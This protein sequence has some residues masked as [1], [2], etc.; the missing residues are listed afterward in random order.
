MV[1][2]IRCIHGDERRWTEP[3]ERTD[4]HECWTKADGSLTK[5]RQMLDETTIDVGQN[6]DG[7]WTKQN[8]WRQ[9]RQRMT[10]M[11]MTML[12]NDLRPWALQRWCVEEKREFFFFY[13]VFVFL[14]SS[15]SFSRATTRAT[16]YMTTSSKT[17]RSA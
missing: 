14:F 1:W 3:D 9:R 12:Q 2:R 17:H 13:F 7:C 5:L 11:S 10:T 8:G 4:V 16:H 6:H 15:S